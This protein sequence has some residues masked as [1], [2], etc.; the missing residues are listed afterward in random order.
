VLPSFSPSVKKHQKIAASILRY[1]CF[2]RLPFSSLTS[3]VGG[4]AIELVVVLCG[5]V[6]WGAKA[7]IGSASI[8]FGLLS[9][10]CTLIAVCLMIERLWGWAVGGTTTVGSSVQ[11]CVEDVLRSVEDMLR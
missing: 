7:L 6:K 10:P 11:N 1:V 3:L 9:V 2:S 8:P 4:A 5:D